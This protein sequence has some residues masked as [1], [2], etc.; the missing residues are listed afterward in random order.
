MGSAGSSCS[1]PSLQQQQQLGP[2]P[3][4][5][6][7]TEPG[8]ASKSKLQ[9][10][11]APEKL[12][13]MKQHDQSPLG[14]CGNG[15]NDEMFGQKGMISGLQTTPSPQLM[16]YV[17]G[18]DGQE[19]II[20]KQLNMSYKSG[21][22]SSANEVGCPSLD[23]ENN[24]IKSETQDQLNNNNNGPP[25]GPLNSM[26]Q[27]TNSISGNGCPKVNSPFANNN[28][29]NQVKSPGPSA[30][31]Q[32]GGPGSHPV[33]PTT[34][35]QGQQPAHMSSS[36]SPAMRAPPMH[37]VGSPFQQQP[38]D[39]IMLMQPPMSQTPPVNSAPAP[40]QP[41][42]TSKKTS[43]KQQQQQQRAMIEANMMGN[44]PMP[45]HMSMPHQQQQ[46]GPPRGMQPC[47][48]PPNHGG[49]I[50]PRMFPPG[51]QPNML[52]GPPMGPGGHPMINQ[53][54]F[55]PNPNFRPPPGADQFGQM[56]GGP[57][58]K[59][60]RM[61]PNEQSDMLMFQNNGMLPSQMMDNNGQYMQQQPIHHHQQGH[62]MQGP[63]GQQQ[64]GMM[65]MHAPGMPPMHQQ[66]MMNDPAMYQQGPPSQ[67]P[68][69]Q[70]PPA[71]AP[72]TTKGIYLFFYILFF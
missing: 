63:P 51:A 57:P 37:G 17:D 44:G 12:E 2:P 20:T 25:P 66:M 41:T 45:P 13:K 6:A 4:Y 23:A 34:P 42:S 18:Y 8:S 53:N 7:P 24:M 46:L 60:M 55:P 11:G 27:M 21:D 28:M 35:Q 70:Q 54:K 61:N 67:P 33:P 64:P 52:G 19:L 49:M 50:D 10:A 68:P 14:M 31:G 69:Q 3:P 22:M 39:G 48:G 71:P 30:H 58:N 32:Y 15:Q 5:G 62:N 43:K 1:S 47:M 59:I 36:P 9:K 26:L 29:A 38:P 72:S 56:P 40:S 65:M 16:N